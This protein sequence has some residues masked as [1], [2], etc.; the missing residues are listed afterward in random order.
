L[1]MEKITI[2]EK[3]RLFTDSDKEICKEKIAGVV[4]EEIMLALKDLDPSSKTVKGFHNRL[5]DLVKTV[6]QKVAQLV[7]QNRTYG[8]P[9]VQTSCG[10]PPGFEILPIE[11]QIDILRKSRPQLDPDRAV[12]YVRKVYSGLKFPKWVEA[13]FAIIRPG[14]FSPL[15]WE[16]IRIVSSLL[17]SASPFRNFYEDNLNEHI[18]RNTDTE[19]KY[20]IL[21]EQ[22]PGDI[23]I[24]GAQFGFHHRGKPIAYVQELCQKSNTEYGLDEVATGWMLLTHPQ[25]I[26]DEHS[27]E[28]DCPGGQRAPA[29]DNSFDTA[30]SYFM[31]KTGGTLVLSYS[32]N[33]FVTEYSASITA[34]LPL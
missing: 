1:R 6:R 12:K 9:E 30:P 28:A 11:V 16:E 34:S 2:P 14:Y 31:D 5:D 29:H 15:F 10:Y 3:S 24:I 8:E 17:S 4:A 23:W 19:R 32:L 21:K 27:L 22:Q 18:R 25:R 26:K 7:V 20:T 33:G 13:P